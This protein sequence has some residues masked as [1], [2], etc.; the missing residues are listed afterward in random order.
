MEELYQDRIEEMVKL[1]YHHFSLAENWQKAADY[2]RKAAGVA[3]RLDQYQEAVR[4]FENTYSCLLQLPESRTRQKNIVD[5]LYKMFWPLAFLGQRDQA[6]IIC[7]QAESLAFELKDAVRMSKVH[8]QY[9]ISYFYKNQY[10]Q[11]E[12]YCLKILQQS[13][14]SKMD[15]PIEEAKFHLASIYLDLGHW[16]KAADLY[17]EVISN[18]EAS[19]TQNVHLADTPFLLYTHMCHHLGYIRTLQGRIDDANILILKGHTP[20]LKQ[21]SSLET[22]AFCSLWHSSVSAM[23]GEDYGALERVNDVFDIAEETD[24]PLLCYLCCVA[25][26]NALIAVNQF[27]AA[28]EILKKS[29]RWVEGIEGQGYRRYL[30]VVYQNLV[31]VSLE[32]GNPVLAK[33]V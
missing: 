29:L 22:R 8:L 11:A 30:E 15:A 19:G 24:S 1:L 23:I 12:R 14:D 33:E 6:L 32:L 31:L 10:K 2:G 27:E 7:K 9:G 13:Q 28:K 21:I 25:K 16:E 26:G 20:A 3:Y 17:S 5:L 18:R 4:M